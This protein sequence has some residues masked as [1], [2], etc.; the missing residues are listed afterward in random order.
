MVIPT[1][2][3]PSSLSIRAVTVLSIPPLIATNTFPFR[4]MVTSQNCKLQ[5][6]DEELTGGLS[7]GGVVSQFAN[8]LGHRDTQR[9]REPQSCLCGP[10]FLCGPLWPKTI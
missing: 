9:F 10:P 7:I 6:Y 1:T 2:S 5:I 3:Y 4:L 8:L